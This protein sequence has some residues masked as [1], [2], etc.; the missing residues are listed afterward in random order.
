MPYTIVNETK[1]DQLCTPFG[2]P[3]CPIPKP[4]DKGDLAATTGGHDIPD[5]QKDSFPHELPQVTLIDIKDA[6]KAGTSMEDEITSFSGTI[7]TKS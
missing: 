1:L 3:V 5:G 7:S 4:G 6:P 2:T